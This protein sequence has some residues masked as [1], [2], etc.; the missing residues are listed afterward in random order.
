MKVIIFL[1]LILISTIG[2]AQ[3]TIRYNG[4]IGDRLLYESIELYPDST[5]M[6]TSE[7]DLSFSSYGKYE[8]EKNHLRLN[9]YIDLI[10]P[11]TM[12]IADSIATM[13]KPIRSET[14]IMRNEKMY[15]TD[16]R[17][18]KKKRIKDRSLKSSWSW[19]FG[20]KYVLIKED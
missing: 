5:F 15:R 8:M 4:I 16:N 3:D 11:K 13:E 9:H 20:H 14:F 18:N 2:A 1:F 17:G 19:L 12:N 10:K 7:Y 6:W